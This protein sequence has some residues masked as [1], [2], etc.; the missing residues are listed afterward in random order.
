MTEHV[1]DI[2]L[3]EDNPSEAEL[4][5]NAFKK[6]GLANRVEL[7]ADG[8]EALDFLFRNGAYASRDARTTVPKVVLLDL[9]LPKIDGFEVLRRVKSD[10]RTRAIPM[11]VLT[12]SR[13]DRDLRGAYQLGANSC[14][15][16]PVAFKQFN[17]T[18]RHIC[19]YWLE[20]NQCPEFDP[21]AD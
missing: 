5:L 3:V 19:S 4:T 11:I 10:A 14:I 6:Y 2:L 9:K 20:L 17:E 1:I 16:K 15:I 13:E 7:V 18:V 8:A 12:S 21:Y